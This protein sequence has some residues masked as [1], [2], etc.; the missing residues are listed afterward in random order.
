MSASP[1]AAPSPTTP[2][3]RASV[4]TRALVA[5][6]LAGGLLVAGAL[7]AAAQS[8]APVAAG[9]VSPAPSTVSVTGS[10]AATAAPDMAVVNVGVE[11]TAPTAKAALA[12]Q[13]AAAKALLAAVKRQGV[14]DRDVRTENLT[15]NAVHSYENGVA[16]L[17][18][19]QAAQ[20]FSVKVRDLSRTGAVIQA[21]MDA[22]GEAGRINGVTFDVEDSTALRN[23]ARAAA[24]QDAR[25][26]AAQFA[27]L[28]GRELG[29]LVSIVE[30]DAGRPTPVEMPPGAAAD[31]AVPVAPGQIQDQVTVTAVYELD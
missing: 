7:P 24:F 9:V 26:K 23:K 1:T 20:G 22:A 29:R 16:K 10:G 8:P 18:G 19:Y 31:E 6:A 17:T 13:S 2:T 25:R 12:G 11:V 4:T 5:T 27:K 30:S 15:L 14:A 21:A 3:T 28:S